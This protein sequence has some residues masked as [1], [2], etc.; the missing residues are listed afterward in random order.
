MLTVS[1]SGAM[2]REIF[3]PWDNYTAQITAVVIEPG[4]RS[5]SKAAFRKCTALTAVT[6]PDG[7]MEIGDSAFYHCTALRELTLP[8]SLTTIG[9]SAFE[10]CALPALVLPDAVTEIGEWAFAECAALREISI[11]AGLT[12]LGDGAF[13]LCETLQGFRVSEE[14]TALCNDGRGVL[15]LKNTKELYCCPGG[16]TG[17]YTVPDGTLN[18]KGEAFSGCRKLQIVNVPASVEAI[19]GKAFYNCTVLMAVC[20]LG[21]EPICL[22]KHSPF[23]RYDPL[24]GEDV[25]LSGTIVYHMVDASGWEGETWKGCPLRD[26]DGVPFCLHEHTRTEK[27][28]RPV[29]REAMSA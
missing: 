8:Q 6:L 10:Q 29:L 28:I 12:D 21:N 4:V 2:P 11:G 17:S 16:L 24:T 26:W 14:N 27:R 13:M 5:V 23:L 22:S 1:G 7:L 15:F 18:I 3:Y 20:F 25:P 9:E 19:G